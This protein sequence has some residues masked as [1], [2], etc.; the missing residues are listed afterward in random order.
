MWT[1]EW[2]VEVGSYWFFGYPHGKSKLYPRPPELYYARCRLDGGKKPVCFT[3]NSFIYQDQ[4]EGVWCPVESPNL[5]DA[6][7]LLEDTP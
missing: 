3:P 6:L 5:E 7:K 1:K 4:A 2:P